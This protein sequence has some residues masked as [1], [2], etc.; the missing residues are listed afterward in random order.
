MEII[1]LNYKGNNGYGKS[2]LRKYPDARDFI[3]QDDLFT[4]NP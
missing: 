2:Y 4:H 3:D 1:V